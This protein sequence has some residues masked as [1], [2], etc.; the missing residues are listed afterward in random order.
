MCGFCSLNT[1]GCREGQVRLAGNNSRE[2][3]VEICLNG[4]WGTIC[5]SRWTEATTGLVCQALGLGKRGWCA[6]FP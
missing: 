3:V 1:A 5:D 2:G 6:V 4:Q